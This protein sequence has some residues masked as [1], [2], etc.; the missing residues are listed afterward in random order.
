MSPGKMEG[1][2]NDLALG[3]DHQG[4]FEKYIRDSA[5][6]RGLGKVE[7]SVSVLTAGYWPS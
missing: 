6:N 7:F 3:A 5:G 1:M 2:I 4:D